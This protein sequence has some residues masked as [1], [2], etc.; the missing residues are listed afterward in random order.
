MESLRLA[1]ALSLVLW[2]R[3]LNSAGLR[4]P[5]DG[6]RRGAGVALRGVESTFV[7]SSFGLQGTE[8]E[9][10]ERLL[11]L[12]H[13]EPDYHVVIQ[14]CKFEDRPLSYSSATF[15]IRSEQWQEGWGRFVCPDNWDGELHGIASSEIHHKCL[16]NFV[17]RSHSSGI[18][19]VWMRVNHVG[20]DGVLAQ[21]LLTKFEAESDRDE[22]VF[23][24]H[25]Q[26][27]S[28]FSPKVVE[29]RASAIELQTFIDLT[30]LLEW[31]RLQNKKLGENM[32]FS[33]AILWCLA[34]HD[35]FRKL[36]MGTTV[37]LAPTDE[38]GRGVG[39][40]VITPNDFMKKPNGLAK[41]VKAFNRQLEQ[42]RQRTSEAMKVLNAAAA[43]PAQYERLVL[44]HAL[45]SNQAFGNLGLTILRD[46]SV[47]GAPIG[48]IGHD[49]GFIAI[50]SA[51]LPTQDGGRVACISIKGAR[52]IVEQYA[53]LLQQALHDGPKEDGDPV[54][55]ISETSR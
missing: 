32:T 8:H 29:G 1:A 51:Q 7:L 33:A 4:K 55:A 11:R 6:W 47:F 21:Q 18:C 22:V 45:K 39:V 15:T 52:G 19:D 26:F 12:L 14:T 16:L 25:E 24:R 36:R 20:L 40:V 17:L 13:R 53:T 41:F 28:K 10:Q 42:T 34:K 31:R 9:I 44:R 48:E 54:L 23:P 46:A 38:C 50:G 43:I 35:S 2:N 27:V 49:H 3:S 37:D 30:P 5:K